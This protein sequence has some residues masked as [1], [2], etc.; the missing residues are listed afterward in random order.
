MKFP[1]VSLSQSRVSPHTRDTSH[2]QTLNEISTLSRTVC[3][4][5]RA[6]VSLFPKRAKS[7][8]YF[9]FSR[10][11]LA[12]DRS[13]RARSVSQSVI[14]PLLPTEHMAP[15]HILIFCASVRYGISASC[16]FFWHG[17]QSRTSQVDSPSSVS[18]L[19]TSGRSPTS[20][21]SSFFGLQVDSCFRIVSPS[22]FTYLLSAQIL[23]R[24]DLR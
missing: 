3:V 6:G 17:S 15:S 24:T 8:G 5:T 4:S 9:G 7:F 14:T 21:W 23:M 12:R 11:S 22:L 13:W 18:S 1:H 19:R 10:A 16:G 2:D 20:G